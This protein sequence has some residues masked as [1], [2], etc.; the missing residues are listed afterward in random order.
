[1]LP[2]GEGGT[3]SLLEETEIITY[4]YRGALA[5]QDTTGRSGVLHAGEFQ[6]MISD[7]G[8]RQQEANASL[9]DPAHFFRLSLRPPEAEIEGAQ[10]QWRFAEAQRHNVV[11]VVASPDGR[12]GSLP[13]HR[14]AFVHSSVLDPGHHLI[15]ELETG[16]VAWLHI[17][18]GEASM[19]DVVLTR[20]DGVGVTGEPSVSLTAIEHTEVL[21]VDLGVQSSSFASEVTP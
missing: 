3:S 15:H 5:Q 6:H 1:M 18:R 13:L 4:V 8:V 17:I 7:M 10:K 16:H 9:T 21:I 19:R 20:G 2:P 11:C 14:D 12:K